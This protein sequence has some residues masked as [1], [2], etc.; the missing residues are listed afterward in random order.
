[1]D[2]TIRDV[3]ERAQVSLGTTSNYLTKRKPVSA[4]ARQRIEAAIA[5]LGYVPNTAVRVMRGGRSH[6]VAFLVPEAANPYFAEVAKGIEDVAI[7]NGHVV[8]MCSTEGDVE[9]EAQYERVLSEMR[10]RGAIVFPTIAGAD[11]TPILERTGATVVSLGAAA[12][13]ARPSVTVDDFKGGAL[14]MEHLVRSGHQRVAFFGGPRAEL[15]INDRLRGALSALDS[16]GI[17]RESFAR[18]DAPGTSPAARQAG[19]QLLL[20]HP[21]RPTGVICA[22]DMLGLSLEVAAVRAGRAIPSDLAIVGY[23]DVEAASTALIPLTSVR[24]PRYELGRA[25]AE[26]VFAQSDV[27][28]H[29]VLEPELIIRESTLAVA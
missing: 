16:H 6:A 13:R 18:V 24:Q 8:V 20:E 21:L 1:M 22:N 27:P 11:L 2:V 7:S 23:D 19:A 3:A 29:V 25:A 17:S 5:E 10:V 4:A 28:S 14:A 26:L 15:Q 12:G 9:R